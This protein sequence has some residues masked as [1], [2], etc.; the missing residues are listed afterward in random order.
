MTRT[1]QILASGSSGNSTFI[2][3]GETRL[4][5]DVGLSMKRLRQSL[6][7]SGE[8]VDDLSAVLLTHEHSDHVSGLN[9]LL[10]KRPDLP[11]LA[12]R[13]TLRKLELSAADTRRIRAGKIKRWADIDVVPFT[14]SHDAAEPV[15][16]RLEWGEFAIGIATDLGCWSEE[17]AE[18]LHGCPFIVVE[19]NHDPDMLRRGPYPQFLKRRVCGQRG[20]LDNGQTRALLDRVA[21]PCIKTVV[22]AHLSE[23]NN[24]AALATD[25]A[26]DVFGDAVDIVVGTPRK[27]GA[28]IDAL[29]RAVFSGPPRQLDLF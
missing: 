18:A 13:G 25:A 4:L 22:L 5:I 1:V 28:P 7:A 12:T 6:E 23:T 3:L 2:R 29:G 10:K 24:T 9:G 27:A 16:L 8:S 20:H 19:A 14:V 15:G 11:V 26:A 21:D 17:V